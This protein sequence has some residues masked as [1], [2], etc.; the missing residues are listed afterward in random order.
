MKSAVDGDSFLEF[1]KI[2]SVAIVTAESRKDLH[3]FKH[4]YGL[5]HIRSY[6]T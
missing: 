5:E 6:L 1:D 3:S 2:S 4:C